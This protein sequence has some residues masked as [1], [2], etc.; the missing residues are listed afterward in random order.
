[1]RCTDI[2]CVCVC[3]QKRP[4]STDELQ[5]LC[6]YTHTLFTHL[7]ACLLHKHRYLNTVENYQQQLEA[8]RVS[9]A[10]DY[11]ILKI[12]LETDIQNLEQHLEVGISRSVF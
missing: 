2:R 6:T 7:H 5:S 9:D 10:E 8:L 11:H 4:G 3:V 1:M 12:R